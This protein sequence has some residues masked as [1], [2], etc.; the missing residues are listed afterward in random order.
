MSEPSKFPRRPATLFNDFKFAMPRSTKPVEGAKYPATWTWEIGLTGKIMFKVNDGIYGTEDRNAKNK[1]VELNA[2][3]RNS[4]L[5]VLQEAV[6]DKDFAS[7]Q[8]FI[9]AKLYNNQT[10]RFNDTPSVMATFTIIRTKAGEIKVNYAR[11]NYELTFN[12]ADENLLMKTKD[13]NG[14]VVENPGLASRAYTSSFIKFSSK[15]LD[16]EEWN[17]YS[18]ED[19]K[20][21]TGGGSGGGKQ[22]ASQQSSTP[23]DFVDE[24]FD[25]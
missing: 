13:I 19:K 21:K 22:G 10:G 18:R 25:F 3:D 24:D 14:G 16:Q 20:G 15:F 1:E 2:F 7:T 5:F 6:S 12:M 23:S 17:R 4:L 9:R 11:G 8:V